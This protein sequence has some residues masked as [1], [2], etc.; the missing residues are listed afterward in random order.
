MVD[1]KSFIKQLADAQDVKAHYAFIDG[2][3]NSGE[4]ETLKELLTQLNDRKLLS[5]SKWA[6]LAVLER[7][8]ETL[9]LTEGYNSAST[10]LEFACAIAKNDSTNSP[11][12]RPAAVA[13][14]IVAAQPRSV[15]DAVMNA[16]PDLEAAALILH[17]AVIRKKLGPDLSS[18]RSISERLA[19]AKHPLAVLPLSLLD[20]ETDAPLPSYE[21]DSSGYSMPYGLWGKEPISSSTGTAKQLAPIAQ[22]GCAQPCRTGLMNQMVKLKPGYSQ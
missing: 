21:I 11:R 8:M 15:I 2:C 5:P 6:P 7:I 3:A 22:T 14:K 1:R 13:S 20:F 9:A 16:P 10:A 4:I 18:A 12:V 19:S 17:E